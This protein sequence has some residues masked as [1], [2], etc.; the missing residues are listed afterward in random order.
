M[1]ESH[2]QQHILEYI[3]RH[4]LQHQLAPSGLKYTP[5]I[6]NSTHSDRS[7]LQN[8]RLKLLK[9][10]YLPVQDDSITSAALVILISGNLSVKLSTSVI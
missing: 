8:V 4:T 9:T 5:L 6:A 1:R 3:P 2:R 10:S 7:M